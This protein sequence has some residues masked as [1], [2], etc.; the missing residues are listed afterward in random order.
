MQESNNHEKAHKNLQSMRWKVHKF[1]L[2]IA[3]IA[4]NLFVVK[5]EVVPHTSNS[6]P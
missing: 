5:T 2:L 6:N 4:E 3:Q 1:I